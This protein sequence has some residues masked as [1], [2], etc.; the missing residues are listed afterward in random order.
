MVVY[1]TKHT[2][3]WKDHQQ[4]KTLTLA[5]PIPILYHYSLHNYHTYNQ[6]TISLYL[7]PPSILMTK[8]KRWTFTIFYN[9][10]I[11]DFIVDVQM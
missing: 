2:A 4:L 3:H 10:S 9:P 11:F 8:G 6:L 7:I 5:K 1:H